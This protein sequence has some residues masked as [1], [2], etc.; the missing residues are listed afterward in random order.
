[1]AANV[2]PKIALFIGGYVASNVVLKIAPVI[3]DYVAFVLLIVKSESPFVVELEYVFGVFSFDQLWNELELLSEFNY[4]LLEYR[5]L[6][7]WPP[8]K[9]TLGVNGVD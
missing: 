9:D 6:F 8:F 1:M 7:R 3:G 2:V 5:Y 4:P